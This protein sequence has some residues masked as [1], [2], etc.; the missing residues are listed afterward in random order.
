MM[1]LQHVSSWDNQAV[2][3]ASGKESSAVTLIRPMRCN[4]PAP[5]S[6]LLH[7]AS[8]SAATPGRTLPSKSSKDAPPPVLQCVTFCSVPYFLHAVAVSPPPM[9]V[10]TPASVP[11]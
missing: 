7:A 10:T 6:P 8:E 9:T 11:M 4:A 5:L 2:K 3:L 1:D